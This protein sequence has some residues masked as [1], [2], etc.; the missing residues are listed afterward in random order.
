MR[1]NHSLCIIAVL[2]SL[3]SL[4][5]T[6]FRQLNTY[7]FVPILLSIASIGLISL[8]E[9]GRLRHVEMVAAVTILVIAI[10]VGAQKYS[11]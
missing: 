5:A 11:P 10:L 9:K 7:Y 4:W 8:Q 1:N 2:F 3:A 6:Q